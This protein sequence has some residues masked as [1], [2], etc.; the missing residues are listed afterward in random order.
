MWDEHVLVLYFFWF[1]EDHILHN[2]MVMYIYYYLWEMG[3]VCA[4]VFLE[5]VFAWTPI[6]YVETIFRLWDNAYNT[7]IFLIKYFPVPGEP[8]VIIFFCIFLRSMT[9][10][11]CIF[12]DMLYIYLECSFLFFVEIIRLMFVLC[13]R[14]FKSRC[15]GDSL[16]DCRTSFLDDIPIKTWIVE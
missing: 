9:C 10:C 1:F 2:E 15:K 14:I 4:Y 7:T 3:I 16:V 8:Y 13:H 11:C 6:N 12:I 5:R